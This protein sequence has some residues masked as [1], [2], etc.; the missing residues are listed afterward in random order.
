MERTVGVAT[1]KLGIIGGMGSEAAVKMFQT[2]VAKTA[3]NS[4]QEH[5]EIVVH[6]NSR[7]PDRTRAI[8]DRGPSPVPELLRS[9]ALLSRCGVDVIIIPCM[10]SHYFLP[11]IQGKTEIPIINA[12]SET[13]WLIKASPGKISRVG[14][15]ATTGSVKS[16]L[17]QKE[18]SKAGLSSLLPEEDEQQNLVM[19]AI[20][21]ADGIKAGY[22]SGPPR[23]KLIQA[24]EGLIAKGAEGLIAGCTEI[25]LA[26][27]LCD[28]SVPL[29]DPIEVLAIR[30]IEFCGG[31]IRGAE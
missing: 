22:C 7:V 11:Q 14:I 20:Y 30:A 19:D 4:D 13:A 2:V 29:I 6:N 23:R 1:K 27:S 16:G 12:I 31:K 10:T 21:G 26:L 8:L 15:L 5:L 25:P 18:L 17:F 28:V 9:V 3:A 24:A